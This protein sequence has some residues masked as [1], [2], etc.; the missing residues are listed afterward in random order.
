MNTNMS[1]PKTRPW[2]ILAMGRGK[3]IAA[4]AEKRLHELGYPNAKVLSVENDQASDDHLVELLKSEQ[5]DGVS[6]GKHR[7]FPME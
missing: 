6:I 5:W 2:K 3:K 1:A 4:E 7:I